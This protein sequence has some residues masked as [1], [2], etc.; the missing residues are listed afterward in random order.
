MGKDPRHGYSSGSYFAKRNRTNQ[1]RAEVKKIHFKKWEPDRLYPGN[2][3]GF[4]IQTHPKHKGIEIYWG[5]KI[6]D[7]WIGYKK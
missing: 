7:I 4:L 3:Y 6:Y 5:K 2:F 1:R